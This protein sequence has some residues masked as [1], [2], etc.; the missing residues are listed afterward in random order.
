MAFRPFVSRF[1]CGV[2]IR[3]VSLCNTPLLCQTASSLFLKL[4]MSEAGTS[5]SAAE[6]G[7]VVVVVCI[8]LRNRPVTFTRE[9]GIP[10]VCTLAKAIREVFKDLP[11]VQGDGELILQVCVLDRACSCLHAAYAFD[12]QLINLYVFCLYR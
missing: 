4:V 9:E 11:G 5:G 10:D 3:L 2:F 7:T 1:G 6:Q 8:G 12:V